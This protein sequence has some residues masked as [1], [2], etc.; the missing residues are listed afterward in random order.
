M[1]DGR[2][3]AIPSGAVGAAVGEATASP[4]VGA[5]VRCVGAAG[6]GDVGSGSGADG[7]GVRG[8]ADGGCSTALATCDGVG[9]SIDSVGVAAGG[10]RFGRVTRSSS[11][12]SASI[13]R[14]R[15][16]GVGAG[17]DAEGARGA[18]TPTG[19]PGSVAAPWSLR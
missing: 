7:G 14:G 3:G 1:G 5:S 10:G 17:T 13:R 8:L 18:A 9:G 6:S 19:T 4:S 12:G 11:A 2:V 16:E 15:L